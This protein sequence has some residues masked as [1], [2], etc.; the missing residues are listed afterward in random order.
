[1]REWPD[2]P[3]L[4]AEGREGSP[5]G[6]CS[7]EP[8]QGK[9]GRKPSEWRLARGVGDS[10]ASQ[11]M[12]GQKAVTSPYDACIIYTFTVPDAIYLKYQILKNLCDTVS[13]TN[14]LIPIP[15]SLPLPQKHTRTQAHTQTTM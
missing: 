14:A 9:S 7:P 1:M 15:Y 8:G 10:K 2:Q 12:K 4:L 5:S 3:T 6:P 11:K 13:F